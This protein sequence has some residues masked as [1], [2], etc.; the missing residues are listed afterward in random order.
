MDE[1]DFD[2]PKEL[3]AQTPAHPRHN[4]RLLVF[5]RSTGRMSDDYFY[6]LPKLLP[7]ETT[8]VL[9]NSRVEKAR[10]KFGQREVFLVKTLDPKTVEALVYP[11]KD[12]QAG[13]TLELAEGVS[14]EILKILPDGQRVLHFS[15]PLDSPELDK[16]RQTPFPPYIK[17]DENLASEYQT[18]YAK[19]LGSKAAPTAGLHFSRAF[20]KKVKAELPVAEITLHVGLGTFAPLKPANLQ[21]GRLHEE[22]YSI[23]AGTAKQLNS[24]RHITAVG[25]TTLRALESNRQNGRFRAGD[26]STDIFIRP[27]YEFKAAD[28]LITNFHL[29]KSSLLMLVAAF[30]GSDWRKLYQHAV[31]KRYRFY[32]FG[33][34]MLIR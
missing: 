31:S 4:A 23:S 11:G 34:A 29:P 19:T 1:F 22:R 7:A 5:D 26:F 13:R 14:A 28:A 6:N 15:L 17:P 10:L 3:I 12:F 9:N 25:T 21:T 2:L 32:S 16:Y 20:L 8:L 18:V 24:A 27:G 33:D 30:V